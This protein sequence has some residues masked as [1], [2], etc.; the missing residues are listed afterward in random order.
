M[1]SDGNLEADSSQ[2]AAS[3]ACDASGV[4]TSPASGGRDYN[5]GNVSPEVTSVTLDSTCQSIP[6]EYVGRIDMAYNDVYGNHVAVG[7]AR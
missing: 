2:T 5:S 3:Y 6:L 7:R 4:T 1:D